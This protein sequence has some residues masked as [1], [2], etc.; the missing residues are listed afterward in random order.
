MAIRR[1]EAAWVES[2]QRWQI[3]VTDDDGNRKMFV[4]SKPG[5]KGKLEA[6]RKADEWL[7]EGE[8]EKIRFEEAWERFVADRKKYCGE[9]WVQKIESIGKT[10]LL[11]NNRKKRLDRITQQDWKN[12]ITD[13]FQQGRSKKTLENIRGVISSFYVFCDMNRLPM[14]EPKHLSIPDG[15]P[16]GERNILDA[17]DIRTLFT[18]DTIVRR[19]KPVHEFYIYAWRLIVVLGLRRGELAGLKHSDIE[20]GVLH[21]R[22]AVNNIGIVTHGKTKNAARDILL[23]DHAIKILDDQAAMLKRMGIATRT[24][25][26]PGKDG[27]MMDTNVMYK[28]WCVYKKQHG[29]KSNLHEL[30]H[31]TVSLVKTEL[32][33]DLLKQMIGHSKTMDTGRYKHKVDGDMQRTAKIIDGV[34]EKLV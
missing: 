8:K 33:E 1:T 2:R 28:R 4:S 30:R 23:P 20:D 21:I 5:K 12:C 27:D 24:W 29:I 14:E 26:F 15:A 7:S 13:A 18:Q 11:P 32:P 3:K 25:V 17:D 19:G 22:R 9:A 34:F 16:V 10:W 6:E 31:T